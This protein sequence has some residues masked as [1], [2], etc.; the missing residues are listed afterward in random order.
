MTKLALYL[1]MAAACAAA[2]VRVLVVYHS[3][4]GNTEKMAQAVRE[5]AASV[6]G[7]EAI[8]RKAEEA[9][10]EDVVSADGIVLGSP[11]YWQNL[12]PVARRFLDRMGEALSKSGKTLGEGRVAGVFCTA[13]AVASGKD[14]TRLSAIAAFLAMRFVVVG[15]VDAEGFGTLGPAATTGPADP[16]ISEQERAE[17]RGFGERFARV[18]LSLRGA[19]RK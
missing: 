2:P 11:V 19:A 7:V 6:A 13:G 14:V 3:A 15:G 16:G 1:C 9:T 12:T 17:A 18:T 8:A 10:A 4:T 5:G